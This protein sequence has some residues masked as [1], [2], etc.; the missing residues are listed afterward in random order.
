MHKLRVAI[1]NS[2]NNGPPRYLNAWDLQTLQKC[3]GELPCSPIWIHL[4]KDKLIL[5]EDPVDYDK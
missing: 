1:S 4:A 5:V 2:S 3:R